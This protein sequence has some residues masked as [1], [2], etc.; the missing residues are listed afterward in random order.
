MKVYE[1][2]NT[3]NTLT[4]RNYLYFICKYYSNFFSKQN[5]VFTI[6]IDLTLSDRISKQIFINYYND[7]QTPLSL[8]QRW[9][10]PKSNHSRSIS[11]QAAFHTTTNT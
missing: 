8:E 5:C 9:T 7:S 1:I 4:A 10:L 2:V 3:E 6:R 11:S